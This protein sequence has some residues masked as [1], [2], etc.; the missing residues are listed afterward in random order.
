MQKL[1]ID[2]ANIEEIKKYH[3]FGLISGVTTNPSLIAKEPKQ[4]FDQLV[5]TIWLYCSENNLSFSV[6]VFATQPRE[7]ID[8]AISIHNTL[9]KINNT[10][11]HLLYIKI[12][13]GINEV[14]CI[15]KL[16]DQQININCTVGYTAIQMQLAM[17]AGAKY[18]SVFYQRSKDCGID[19]I[20]TIQQI[21]RFIDTNHMV[22]TKIISCSL[23]KPSDISDVWYAG[24]DIATCSPK[25]IEQALFHEGSKTTI[26]NFV[27][28]FAE[29]I[30]TKE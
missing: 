6:E 22:D 12:P 21:K 30:G 17:L 10:R 13:I 8:Q 25:I 15:K 29:W 9:L 14:S 3:T 24:S 7:I 16:S 28:D 27:K 23:R 2:T 4:N 1:F 18:V 19:P 11:Q 26:N 20:N 5:Q